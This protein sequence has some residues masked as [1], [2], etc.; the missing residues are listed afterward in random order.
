MDPDPY[1]NE[2]DPYQNETDPQTLVKSRINLAMG[3]G[4][5][6]K[7]QITKFK[8]K[9]NSFPE[10]D[11]IYWENCAL[12]FPKQDLQ[13]SKHPSLYTGPTFRNL[14]SDDV[15]YQARRAEGKEEWEDG[16][17]T[18]PCSCAGS[19]YRCSIVIRQGGINILE[20]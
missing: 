3:I 10:R 2:T 18:K 8:Y 17:N 11:N 15:I 1:K 9:K 6:E 7:E 19:G 5:E 13:M 4:Y 16:R 20:Y 12:D 14:K